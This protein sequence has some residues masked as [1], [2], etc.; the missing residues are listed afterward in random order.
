[1]RVHFLP[2]IHISGVRLELLIAVSRAAYG[3][4]CH[5]CQLGTH[6]VCVQVSLQMKSCRSRANLRSSG[7]TL[8]RT[9]ITLGTDPHQDLLI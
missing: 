3:S 4:H 2:G 5:H 9:R 6:Q 8:T 7:T 1:M